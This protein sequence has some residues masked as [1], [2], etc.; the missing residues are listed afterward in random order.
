MLVEM[1]GIPYGLMGEM[2]DNPN[3]WH[4][5]VFGE[6]VRWPW[7]G[8][9]HSVWKVMDLFGI[10]DSEFI[11]WWDPACPVKTGLPQVKVSVYRKKGKT[12]VALASWATE[13]V[14]VT[15]TVDWNALGLDPQKTTLWAPASAGF[16]EERVFAVAGAVPVD[17]GKGWLLIADEIPREISAL[18]VPA[19]PL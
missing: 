13:R 12:L 16:Q 4:G 6:T 5:M 9:P 7:S 19:D 8:D 1:S 11:G 3:P 14:N 10:S 2:L 17:P 15:L 18:P